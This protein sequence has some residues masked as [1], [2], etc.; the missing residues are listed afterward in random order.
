MAELPTL[1]IRKAVQGDVSSIARV[2]VDSW[3][4][5]YR[6][7]VPDE[8]LAKLSYQDRET[9]WTRAVT[10]PA[11]ITFVAEASER[12]IGFANGGKNRGGESEYSGELYAVYL[13]QAHQQRGVGRQLTLAIAKEL[14]DAGRRSMIVWVLRNNPACEFY[15]KLGGNL[16]ASKLIIIG[17]ASL[18]EVAYG[19]SDIGVLL[20]LA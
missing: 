8:H 3:Q 17:G 9:I 19:W 2:H 7:I 4:T 12:I 18:E 20:G 11:Q 15:K 6:G 13:L 16:V 14:G 10:D 1:T 5:T